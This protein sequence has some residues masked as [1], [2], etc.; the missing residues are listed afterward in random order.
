MKF[1]NNWSKRDYLA[2][3]VGVSLALSVPLVH[4]ATKGDP[5]PKATN[6]AIQVATA[7]PTQMFPAPRFMPGRNA[8]SLYNNGPNTIWCGWTS[9]VTTATGFPVTAGGSLSVDLV[10]NG[11]DSLYCIASTALQVTP[12]DTRWI[13]VK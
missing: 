11:S 13:Q 6:G 7:S 4:A 5:L 1:W 9:A 12:A 3:V 2:V 10:T 8:F